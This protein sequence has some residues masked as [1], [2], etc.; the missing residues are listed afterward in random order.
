M[1]RILLFCI[2]A[3]LL[4]ASVS[5]LFY[6]PNTQ[7]TI[8]AGCL[9]EST[10]QHADTFA[11]VTIYYP[12]GSVYLLNQQMTNYTTGLFNYSHITANL[13]GTYS[14]AVVCEKI[15]DGTQAS[16]LFQYQLKNLED[17]NGMG[18]VALILLFLGIAAYLIFM[19]EKQFKMAKYHKI[20]GLGFYLISPWAIVIAL[21][22]ALLSSTGAAYEQVLSNFFIVSIYAA[23]FFN[24]AILIITSIYLISEKL[25]ETGK[26]AK[27]RFN[28]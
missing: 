12:N 19:G 21:Y 27:Q 16:G 22:V 8:Q 1:K 2:V 10:G 28:K 11:N 5:A 6:P 26:L 13:T 24:V 9:D 4:T 15:A 3:I 18:Q 25:T 23:G 14:Y 20:V 17:E 7:Q